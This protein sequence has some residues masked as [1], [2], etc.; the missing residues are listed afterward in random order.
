MLS[1]GK[2]LPSIRTY[3]PVA[4]V[5]EGRSRGEIYKQ[6]LEVARHS[7]GAGTFWVIFHGLQVPD[8]NPGEGFLIR[9]LEQITL[10][11]RDAHRVREVFFLLL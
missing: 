2:D 3:T 5:G 8:T 6:E 4:T 7:G 9:S 11:T 10:S 1:E